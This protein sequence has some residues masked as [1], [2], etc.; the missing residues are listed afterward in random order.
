MKTSDNVGNPDILIQDILALLAESF[1][2]SEGAVR[3]GRFS[4]K[5]WQKGELFPNLI[6]E[7]GAPL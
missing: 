7:V 3:K 4:K 6:L 5:L 2:T 1:L